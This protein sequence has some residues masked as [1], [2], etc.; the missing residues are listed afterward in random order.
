[1]QCANGNM[2]VTCNDGQ[3]NWHVPMLH[4]LQYFLQS[5]LAVCRSAEQ[6]SSSAQLFV[7]SWQSANNYI[8]Q[9]YIHVQTDALKM[10]KQGFN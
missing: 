2:W 1:M 9:K 4:K 3:P 8:K 6:R 5:R 10:L 7:V